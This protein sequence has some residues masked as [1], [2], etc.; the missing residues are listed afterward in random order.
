MK[1]RVLSNI[2]EQLLAEVSQ[3]YAAKDF[4]YF[5]I[6]DA[7]SVFKRYPDVDRLAALARMLLRV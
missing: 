5:N 2:E 4:E 7:L 3:I 6:A 1:E